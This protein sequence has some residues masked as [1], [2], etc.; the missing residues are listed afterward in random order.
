MHFIYLAFRVLILCGYC[1]FSVV[2]VWVDLFFHLLLCVVLLFFF[3]FFFFLPHYL[4]KTLFQNFSSVL[5]LNGLCLIHR[6]LCF[7]FFFLVQ[8]W[9]GSVFLRK[10]VQSL[11][12][13]LFLGYS[14]A[15]SGLFLPEKKTRT[16]LPTSI[17]ILQRQLM[18][19]W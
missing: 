7:F 5:H 11:T 14:N 15:L 8:A 16:C 12:Y 6:F 1:S 18:G 3:F 10:K 19:H 9:G 17:R 4:F 13:C 2:Q